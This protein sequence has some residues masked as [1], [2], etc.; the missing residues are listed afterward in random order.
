MRFLLFAISITLAAQPALFPIR[1]GR[2]FGFI[3]RAGK[4]V[5]PPKFDRVEEFRENRSVV[6]I[7]S[8]A[9]Y[10]DPAGRL[11]IPAVFST[12]TSFEEGRAVVSRDGKYSVIDTQGKTIAEIPH[13]VMG[14]YSSGL[15]VVQRARAGATPSAYGYIDRNGKVVIEPRFMPAGKFPEDGRGLA[16][17]GLEREWCYFDK[18]GEI[19]LRLPMDGHDRAPGFKDGL[20]RWK[21]GFHW[22]YRDVK[23][24]WAIAPKFDDARDFENGVAGVQKDGK[25]IEIDT[26]GETLPSTNG[27]RAIHPQSDGLTLARDGDRLG[28][29]SPDGKP[30]FEFRKYDGA[31]DYQCGMARI[32]LD[33]KFGF[34]D[35]SGRLVLA[36]QYASATDFKGCLAM[37]MTVDGWTYIDPA[38]KAVWK[39]E[40]RF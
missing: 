26:R 38:G 5:I 16:V 18:T 25:W 3:D 21:D 39:S 2:Q 35:K 27:P 12:A 20:L 29:L 28:Y 30:A 10:I 11:V 32:K 37:V 33:G 17:G 34:M 40:T 8:N 24:A 1:N 9:G 4:V 23:G 31:F 13:R 15:A 14:D 22:G 36:N 19:I 7:G 6:W